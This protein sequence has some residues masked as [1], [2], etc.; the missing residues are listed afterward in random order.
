MFFQKFITCILINYKLN[1]LI[2]SD[3]VLEIGGNLSLRAELLL[4]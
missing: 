2:R 4:R 1:E 3:G